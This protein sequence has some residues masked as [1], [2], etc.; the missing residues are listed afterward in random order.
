MISLKS[1]SLAF[2]GII[3]I[4]F[5]GD[6]PRG[7]MD[8]VG[9]TNQSAQNFQGFGGMLA[10]VNSEEGG[11]QGLAGSTL[12]TLQQLFDVSSEDVLKRLKLALVPF[13]GQEDAAN[14][15][16]TRWGRKTR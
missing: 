14:D 8:S 2:K 7:I 5:T 11:V 12:E 1:E 10:A 13:K 6:A 16:R 4:L 9:P 3:L 15:F